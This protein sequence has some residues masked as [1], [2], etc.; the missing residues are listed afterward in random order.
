MADSKTVTEISF[1]L[2]LNWKSRYLKKAVVFVFITTLSGQHIRSQIHFAVK[3]LFPVKKWGNWGIDAVTYPSLNT[4]SASWYLILSI[5]FT[6]L[7]F[8]SCAYSLQCLCTLKKIIFPRGISV[9]SVNLVRAASPIFPL[10]AEGSLQ[11]VFCGFWL[12]ND[13]QTLGGFSLMIFK[14]STVTDGP[15]IK[16]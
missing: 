15:P 7:A 4:L 13:L 10:P 6:G 8:N 9:V 11:G 1:T 12:A 14:F 3:Y 2:F 5:P 16:M